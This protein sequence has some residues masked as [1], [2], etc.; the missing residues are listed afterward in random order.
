MLNVQKQ[1]EGMFHLANT[2]SLLKLIGFLCASEFVNRRFL[3]WLQSPQYLKNEGELKQQAAELQI[4]L[5]EL[6]DSASREF[7]KQKVDY[8]PFIPV[9]SISI[10]G[11]DGKE[12]KIK[13][14]RYV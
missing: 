9:Y 14:D 4:S 8:N 11:I 6:L 1:P 2:R 13:F 10:P 3:N 12:Y 5:Q 7:E